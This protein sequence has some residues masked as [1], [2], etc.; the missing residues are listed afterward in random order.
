MLTRASVSCNLQ[1]ARQVARPP[2][3]AHRHHLRHHLP[4]PVQPAP[5]GIHT[6]SGLLAK[7]LVVFRLAATLTAD[8]K[9]KQEQAAEKASEQGNES[10][11]TERERKEIGDRASE[12]R[13]DRHTPIRKI[14]DIGSRSR[15]AGRRKDAERGASSFRLKRKFIVSS[16]K[17]PATTA[18]Q[19]VAPLTLESYRVITGIAG[20][21]PQSRC[22]GLYYAYEPYLVPWCGIDHIYFIISNAVTHRRHVSAVAAAVALICSLPSCWWRWRWQWRWCRWR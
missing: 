9:A 4:P 6:S 5:S 16:S 13:S 21:L 10:A 8:R 15:Q 12:G 3:L 1:Q 22:S 18:K 11:M 7:R 17:P 14:R 2:A 19:S 20:M